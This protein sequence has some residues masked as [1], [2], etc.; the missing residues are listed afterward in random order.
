M[1]YNYKGNTVAHGF[2]IYENDCD[3]AGIYNNSTTPIGIALYHPKWNWGFDGR[4]PIHFVPFP[5]EFTEVEFN[6]FIDGHRYVPDSVEFDET[7]TFEEIDRECVRIS[8]AAMGIPFQDICVDTFVRSRDALLKAK[9]PEQFN[10]ACVMA[11]QDTLKCVENL[12]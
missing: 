5:M 9:E 10:R 1:T 3:K 4:V 8:L 7:L 6:N 2:H 12:V 11:F